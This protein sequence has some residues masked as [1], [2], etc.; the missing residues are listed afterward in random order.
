MADRDDG[1][2]RTEEPTR[3]RLDEALKKGDAPKSQELVAAIMLAAALVGLVALAG[4]AA[5]SLARGGTAFI[6][7]PHDFATDAG[8]LQRLFVGVTVNTGVALAAVSA[9]FVAAAILAHA[10]QARPVLNPER[11]A[12]NLARLSPIE[13]IKRIYG[14]VA[15][16]NLLKGFFKIL[17][18]GAILLYALWPDRSL[19]IGLI[20]GDGSRLLAG[21]ASELIKLLMLTVAAMAVIA[22]LDYA[23]AR[24]TWKNRLKMTKEEVRR[25]LKESEGD[26]LIRGRLKQQREARARRRMMAAVKNATVLIMNPTHYAVALKYEAGA[27]GAP[28]CVAK[29]VDQTALRMKDV[30]NDNGVA[31]V[32]NPPLARALYA[33]AELDAE[34]P[35]EHYETVA[36]V[37]GFILKKA[38]TRRP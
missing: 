6:D 35:V 31:V 16:F 22:G 2:Q 15:L 24:R 5:T 4:P 3:K 18:V 19:L 20:D 34:I 17:I 8:A 23:W 36:K 12:F 25:E 10:G 38:E 7:H 33:A 21:S 14:P 28:V 30:A 27:A 32:E 37:I 26:P 1:A 29:G 11:L 13:G 9:L